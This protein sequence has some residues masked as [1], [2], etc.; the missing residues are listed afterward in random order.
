[1]TDLNSLVIFA[2]VADAG[3]FSLAARRLNMPTSTVS[4]RIA[5]LENELGV[6]LLE[7]STR[8]LRLTDVGAELLEHARRS[9]ELSEAVAS[10]VSNQ[11]SNISGLLRLSAPPSI[12]DTMLEP[13]ARAFQAS[14]PDVRIQIFI[15]DRYIDHIAEGIDLVFRIGAGAERDSSLVARKIMTYR[16][17]LLASPSYL[18]G[19]EP[20]RNPQELL[21]HRLIAFAFF[22]PET[23]WTF[24]H[25]NGNE[26]QTIAFLP[27]LSMNDFTGL[28]SAL[29]SGSGI[30]DLPP[31]V[32]PDLVRD[33]RLVEVLPDWRFRNF[34]LLMVHLG[35]RHITRTVRVFKEFAA[36]MVPTLFPELPN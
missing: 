21:A 5:D 3:S 11:L 33:G 14:Y 36:Q 12:A 18:D 29:V 7:R 10:A 1:M 19:C 32:R 13:L 35:N 2:K 25:V 16:H 4:R 23:S 15:T 9:A 30:G 6:R 34:D 28:A 24:F 8:S 22:K 31:V 26:Q 20:P 27:H 17:R